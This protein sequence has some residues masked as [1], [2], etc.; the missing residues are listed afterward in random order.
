[1][2]KAIATDQQT[3]FWFSHHARLLLPDGRG[4][5][6]S[7]KRT[8]AS[9]HRTRNDPAYGRFGPSASIYR[10]GG[11]P[12]CIG[13]NYRN[14]SHRKEAHAAALSVGQFTSGGTRSG[15]FHRRCSMTQPGMPCVER[16]R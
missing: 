11:E 10:F 1:M 2:I 6:R 8:K 5:C 7:D 16:R 9:R 15:G 13:S 4:G 3:V 12:D 14:R